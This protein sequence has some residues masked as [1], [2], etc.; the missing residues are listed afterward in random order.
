MLN[1][2]YFSIFIGNNG[3]IEYSITA[4]DEN[5]DFVILSNGTI[6]TQHA[7]DR[8]TIPMYN[9]VVTALD[10]AKEP[11]R[12][13]SSTVQVRRTIYEQHFILYRLNKSP[14]AIEDLCYT[15]VG[16]LRHTT[17]KAKR[18]FIAFSSCLKW[19]SLAA[20]N[21]C[22]QWLFRIDLLSFDRLMND[23]EKFIR[24]L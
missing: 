11:E 21:A 9:L 2:W 4:G 15:F 14:E 24:K 5:N 16:Q 23:F 12:R 7:L 1:I 6:R 19:T 8:E 22:A 17:S 3:R 20:G 13:L 18:N 10:C